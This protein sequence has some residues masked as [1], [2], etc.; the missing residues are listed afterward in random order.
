MPRGPGVAHRILF[1]SILASLLSLGTP[2]STIV[3]TSSADAGAGSLRQAVAESLAGD[4]ITFSPVILR[5]DLSS[6]EI[7][8]DK[9]LDIRGPS[10]N[11]PG[12]QLVIDAGGTSRVFRITRPAGGPMPVVALDDLALTGG[13]SVGGNGGALYT[14]GRLTLLRCSIYGNTATAGPGGGNGGGIY[15][16]GVLRVEAS[17]LYGNTAYG[18]AGHGDTGNGGGICNA[19]GGSDTVVPRV[20]L[21]NCTLSGNEAALA[22]ADASRNAVVPHAVTALAERSGLGGGLFNDTRPTG[23]AWGVDAVPGLI[24]ADHCTVAFNRASSGGG[25]ANFLLM[26]SETS[27]PGEAFGGAVFFSGCIVGGNFAADEGGAPDLLG[28][29]LA[30]DSLVQSTIGNLGGSGNVTG[31]DCGLLPLGDNGGP[32][33]AHALQPWSPAVNA[34]SGASG[35]SFDQTGAPRTVA[36]RAD[37]GAWEYPIEPMPLGKGATAAFQD[38][39]GDGVTVALTGP[40]EGYVTATSGADPVDIVLTGT[41]GSTV[42]VIATSGHTTVRRILV[43]GRLRALRA[44]NVDLLSGLTVTRGVKHLVLRDL[45]GPVEVLLGRIPQKGSV[46]Q[47]RAVRDCALRCAGKI[48]RMT[49]E[50]WDGSADGAHDLLQASKIGRLSVEG[51]VRKLRIVSGGDINEVTVGG[52]DRSYILA[53]AAPGLVGIADPRSD[54]VSHAGL[55]SFTVTGAVS[56]ATGDQFIDGVVAAWTIGRASLG[57]VRV[58]DK[59]PTFGLSARSIRH[60]DYRLNGEFFVLRDLK[61]FADSVRDGRFAVSLDST[62]D[63]GF[64]FGALDDSRGDLLL[65]GVATRTLGFLF[66]HAAEDHCRFLLVP[67]DLAAG[68]MGLCM[69]DLTCALFDPDGSISRAL[70]DRQYPEFLR[71]AAAYGYSPVGSPGQPPTLYPT[72]G[73]HE[74]YLKGDLSRE[75]W[76]AYIG[77]HLP[78]NGPSLGTGP[79]QN[80]EMD[81]RG[82]TYSFRCGNSLFLG[83]D[84]YA[85]LEDKDNGIFPPPSTRV[86]SVFSSGWFAEQ[87]GAFQA[88]DSL[89]H[90]FVFGHSPLYTIKMDT[91]MEATALTAAGRDVF[92]RQAGSLAEIYF[93][94]HEHFYD[95]TIISG[96]SHPGGEGIDALHQVLVGTG[97]AEIDRKTEWDCDYSA[98]YIRDPARQYYH[99]PEAPSSG[100][101]QPYIGYNVVTVSGPEVAFVWKA[102]RVDNPCHLPALP[103]PCTLCPW[104]SVDESPVFLNAWS[105][106][107]QGGG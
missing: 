93:C 46:I 43:Q 15:N 97:G 62:E 103:I 101:P 92:V 51:W 95:H 42:L 67:G 76:T 9:G 91:S 11:S 37:S 63:L 24:E 7:V 70:S 102:W 71:L 83:I 12:D 8:I 75:Q 78:Q 31:Q 68:Y 34:S 40:G 14:E 50:S 30:Q 38:R 86:P 20:T 104:C 57:A 74:C 49:V 98:S 39:D 56:D 89:A 82:F 19:W 59:G 66:Q 54:L 73:N 17:T 23:G 61:N 44:P 107:V 33:L 45:P 64:T 18:G 36:G 29:A 77:R 90:C 60:M 58:V 28:D 41:M 85:V 27:G 65:P 94:G 55:A 52:L 22:G 84:E 87:F 69:S 80:P 105:Y 13:A 5:V 100:E 35:L 106:S 48:R 88:D 47:F 26:E 16:T 32:T 25:V 10:A 3:V 4:A 96:T 99:N 79:D 1:L 21:V 72:R 6:G 81:E 53:G 2:G